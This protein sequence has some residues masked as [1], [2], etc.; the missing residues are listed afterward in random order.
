M[1]LFENFNKD[2]IAS[3]ENPKF[4]KAGKIHDWRNYVLHEF[5]NEWENLTLGEKQAM[6]EEWY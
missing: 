6:D 2:I 4:E 1:K 5:I 3:L